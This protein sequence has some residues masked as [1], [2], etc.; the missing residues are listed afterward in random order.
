M[1]RRFCTKLPLRPTHSLLQC[2]NVR[3]I[4]AYRHLNNAAAMELLKTSR[5]R[6]L[7]VRMARMLSLRMFSLALELFHDK[8][9]KPGLSRLQ[10]EATFEAACVLLLDHK[11]IDDALDLCASHAVGGIIGL[12]FTGFFAD[13]TLIA[14][15]GVNTSVPGGWVRHNWKQ[16]YI[17]FAY[18]CATV[19]YTFVV[20]A[21][22]A[23]GIDMLPFCS[24]RA[25]AEEEALGMDDTQVG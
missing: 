15:D 22:L 5:E 14:L 24:L 6:R 8:I 17:Q 12:F 20:T 2:R 7:I 19:G 16:L 1:L 4:P 18:I 21:L 25:T 10:I 23:K 3:A 13:G 11:R 9:S